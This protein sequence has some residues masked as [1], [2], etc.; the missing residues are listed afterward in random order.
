MSRSM[1]L[2]FDLLQIK[3]KQNHENSKSHPITCRG[4]ISE[5]W[6]K[7]LQLGDAKTQNASFLIS[8]SMLFNF[9]QEDHCTA[10]IEIL[11]FSFGF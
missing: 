8:Y 5:F 11:E 7:V 1:T 6:E 2:D 4:Y 10:E 3:G 9:I